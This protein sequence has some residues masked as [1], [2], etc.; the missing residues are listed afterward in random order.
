[1]A[2]TPLEAGTTG[3]APVVAAAIP[4]AQH[5]QLRAAAAARGLTVSALVRQLLSQALGAMP[6]GD[7]RRSR[8]QEA[9]GHHTLGSPNAG[10]GQHHQLEPND[11]TLTCPTIGTTTITVPSGT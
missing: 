1:M 2:Q 9:Q 10:K 5:A 3:K 8:K 6:Q 11:R 7:D 4:R